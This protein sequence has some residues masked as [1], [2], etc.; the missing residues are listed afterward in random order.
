MT[1][2]PGPAWEQYNSGPYW[3]FFK[4]LQHLYPMRRGFFIEV[5]AFDGETKSC[6]APMADHGWAGLMFEPGDNPY[7]LCRERHKDNNVKVLKQAISNSNKEL[8]FYRGTDET[9][10][11]FTASKQAA[12]FYAAKSN[13][14][15]AE[16]A[17]KLNAIT[18]DYYLGSN[19]FKG[20]IDVLRTCVAGQNLE[21][22]QGLT[23][24]EPTIIL[25]DHGP[26]PRDRTIL[27]KHYADLD[28]NMVI[29]VSITQALMA[30]DKKGEVNLILGD[31][32]HM[33]PWLL[34][35]HVFKDNEHLI[36]F[37]CSEIYN[38]IGAYTGPESPVSKAIRIF[39]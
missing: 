4:V 1:D 25:T 9:G 18:L 7:E 38:T 22:I 10:I 15:Q 19:N 23:E 26:V 24:W 33:R 27:L 14:A 30:S 16:K 13:T 28:Y 8:S 37:K 17:Q 5:G 36:S 39:G 3:T 31:H 12:A 21:V 6:T 11:D 35:K 32:L 20:N 29:P 34:T 2:Q